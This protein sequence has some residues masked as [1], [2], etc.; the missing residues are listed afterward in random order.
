MLR[1][2]WCYWC[3]RHRDTR[4]E[5]FQGAAGAQ[6]FQ[7]AAGAQGPQGAQGAQ[8]PA[9]AHVVTNSASISGSNGATLVASV[10]CPT[11]SIAL[12]GGANI[13]G[14]TPGENVSLNRSIPTGSAPPTGWQAQGEQGSNG[15][16]GWQVVVEVVCSP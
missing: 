8:G 10:S 16:T 9:T 12:G 15:A 2:Y 13:T 3:Y 4:I 11:G 5:G 14:A 1:C 6:G 7:G